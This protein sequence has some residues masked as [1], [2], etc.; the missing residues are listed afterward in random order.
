MSLF[1]NMGIKTLDINN[2]ITFAALLGN[3]HGIKTRLRY[4]YTF[5]AVRVN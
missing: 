2:H 5:I 4:K 1:N 3:L